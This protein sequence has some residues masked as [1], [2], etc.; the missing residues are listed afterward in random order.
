MIQLGGPCKNEAKVNV[1]QDVFGDAYKHNSG[2]INDK[3]TKP[4]RGLWMVEMIIG[5][6]ET[7]E[8]ADKDCREWKKESR[9]IIPRRDLGLEIVA[10]KKGKIK[11]YDKR[12]VIID[13]D[14]RSPN[15]WLRENGMECLC[16][17]EQRM[18]A[19]YEV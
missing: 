6:Y 15:T 8:E 14:T 13:P 19:L 9:S 18:N 12:E 4:A 7:Y 11:C 2:A 10:A 16:L 3:G 5:P 1:A 17:P